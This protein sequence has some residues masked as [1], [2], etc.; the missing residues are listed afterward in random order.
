LENTALAFVTWR[1]LPGM[2][3]RPTLGSG[4]MAGAMCLGIRPLSNA[5]N[6]YFI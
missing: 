6:V 2:A 4:A 1:I 3:N 5:L